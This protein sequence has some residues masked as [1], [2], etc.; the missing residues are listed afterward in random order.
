MRWHGWLGFERQG[1]LQDLSPLG[2]KAGTCSPCSD[3]HYRHGLNIPHWDVG[4]N[5]KGKIPNHREIR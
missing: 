1:V 3:P 2:D 5:Q 4:E